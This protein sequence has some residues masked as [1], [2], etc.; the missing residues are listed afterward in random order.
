[1]RTSSHYFSRVAGLAIL[2][3]IV[4]VACSP[5]GAADSPCS[6][7]QTPLIGTV[8][9]TPAPEGAT[10]IANAGQVCFSPITSN[11]LRVQV[12]AGC[13]SSSCTAV[14]ERTGGIEVD[15]GSY[16]ISLQSRFVLMDINQLNGSEEPCACTED[17]GGAGLLEYETGE[18]V[19]GV[20]FV[21]LGGTSI[22]QVSIPLQSDSV[23]LEGGT[24][25]APVQT[26]YPPPPVTNPNPAYP[27]PGGADQPPAYP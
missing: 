1:M 14:F 10:L 24:S 6:K 7:P 15:Q 25:G 23:C 21:S 9:A 27:A 3:L 16:A 5:S 11:N 26:V 19:E 22:G 13:Y 4:L 20:Y 17:C 18:L 2:M 12:S 8:P